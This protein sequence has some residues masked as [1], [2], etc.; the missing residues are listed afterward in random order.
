MKQ[1][2]KNMFIFNSFGLDDNISLKKYVLQTKLIDLE[3][4]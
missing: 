2:T 4:F 1:C 3:F